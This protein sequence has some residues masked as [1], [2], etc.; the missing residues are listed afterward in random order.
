MK[1]TQE[2]W[3][4]IGCI[5]TFFGIIGKYSDVS[6]G[7]QSVLKIG[8]YLNITEEMLYNF[9]I[10]IGFLTLIYVVSL[11]YEKIKES[12]FFEQKVGDTSISD[13]VDYVVN[14]SRFGNTLSGNKKPVKAQENIEGEFYNKK[15]FLFGIKQGCHSSQKINIADVKNLSFQPLFEKNGYIREFDAFNRLKD[16]RIVDPN[17]NNKVIFSDIAVN[18]R[19][20]EAIWKSNG[21]Y[22]YQLF[23]RLSD[24]QMPFIP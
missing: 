7:A 12:G 13:A 10:S 15:I 6:N 11:I 5:I 14:G 24:F 3:T 20:L 4:A 2:K 16:L 22:G 21:R 9:C 18:K 8:E 19:Q 23:K 17:N 1:K